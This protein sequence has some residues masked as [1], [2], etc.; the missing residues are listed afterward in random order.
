LV[1]T[2][3]LGAAWSFLALVAVLALGVVWGAGV[4][5]VAAPVESAALGGFWERDALGWIIGWAG[6]GLLNA[7]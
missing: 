7:S 4:A 3:I 5:L 2:L 6:A 1:A